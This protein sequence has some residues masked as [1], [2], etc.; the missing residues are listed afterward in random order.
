M[1][2]NPDNDVPDASA[3]FPRTFRHTGTR[4]PEPPQTI[5]T[6]PKTD[7]PDGW[8]PLGIADL[9][10]HGGYYVASVTIPPFKIV[11]GMVILWGERCFGWDGLGWTERTMYVCLDPFGAPVKRTDAAIGVIVA[12]ASAVARRRSL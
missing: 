11:D 4:G 6:D 12:R 8:P 9:F 7:N 3:C 10:T 1:P 5:E 2:T